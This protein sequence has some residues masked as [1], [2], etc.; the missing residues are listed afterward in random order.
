MINHRVTKT[1]P[2]IAVVATA[3]MTSLAV[4]TNA[5]ELTK[6]NISLQPA[7]WA[8]PIWAAKEKGWFKE[9]G[10][11]VNISIV[12]ICLLKGRCLSRDDFQRY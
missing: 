10:L 5:A 7:Y 4:V 9:L 3:M 11:D 1:S 8:I 6:V 2:S 12:S